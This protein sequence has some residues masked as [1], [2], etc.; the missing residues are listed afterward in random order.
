MTRFDRLTE[1]LDLKEFQ[2][3]ALLEITKAINNSVSRGEL[4]EIYERITREQL[5]ITRLTLFERIS[6]WKCILSYGT[7]GGAPDVNAEQLFGQV[8]D[9]QLI[10]PDEAHPLAGFDVAVPVFHRDQPLAFLL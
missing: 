3:R 5:G 8:R 9:I 7:P 2:L 6:G 4:L 10:A 1:R